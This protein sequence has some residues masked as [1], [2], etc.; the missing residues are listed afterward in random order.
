LDFTHCSC[1]Y[2]LSDGHGQYADI[3]DATSTQFEGLEI[4]VTGVT[5]APSGT[6]GAVFIN[7]GKQTNVTHGNL[8]ERSVGSGGSGL[9]IDSPHPGR[10][11]VGSDTCVNNVGKIQC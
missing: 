11:D 4:R 6:S 9:D 1:R 7:S 3:T 2:C 8:S 10:V 5:N